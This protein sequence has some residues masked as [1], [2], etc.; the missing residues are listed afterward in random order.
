MS[1]LG[2]LVLTPADLSTQAHAA[3]E[4]AAPRKTMASKVLAAMAFEKVTGRKA[5]PARLLETD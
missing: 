5:D 2:A 4:T 1:N 3:T